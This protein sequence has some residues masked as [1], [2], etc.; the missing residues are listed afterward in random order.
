MS[1]THTLPAQPSLSIAP[2]SRPRPRPRYKNQEMPSA[3]PKIDV[4]LP[5]I[6]PLEDAE[7]SDL[8]PLSSPEEYEAHDIFHTQK[9][10][11]PVLPKS[12]SVTESPRKRQAQVDRDTWNVKALGPYVWV[13]IDRRARVF[14]PEDSDDMQLCS[15]RLWWPGKTSTVSSRKIPLKVRLFGTAAPGVKTVEI[16]RPCESNVVPWDSPQ[17]R[18]SVDEP[19]FVNLGSCDGNIFDSPTKKRKVD[20]DDRKKRWREALE[21]LARDKEEEGDSD[22][23]PEVGTLDFQLFVSASPKNSTKEAMRQTG[24]ETVKGKGKGKRKRRDSDS[25]SDADDFRMAEDER[26]AGRKAQQEEWSP[27]EP[28][29]LL[30]IPGEGVLAA[31]SA[32]CT[33][34]WPAQ[35][36]KYIPPKNSRQQPKYKVEYVGDTTKEI[37]RNWFYTVGDSEFATCEL[38]EW[39][40]KCNEVQDDEDED[41]DIHPRSRSPSPI[42]T[43]PPPEAD[44][45]IHLSVREQFAY[46]KPVLTAILNENY[47]PARPRH[48]KFIAGG[49]KRQST[50]QEAG[51]RGRMDPRDID[52]LEGCLI[53]WCLRD[54]RKAKA[55]IDEEGREGEASLARA[56]GGDTYGVN[57][58]SAD[59][60]SSSRLSPTGS[61]ATLPLS[62]GEVPPESSFP[63]EDSELPPSSAL[64]TSASLAMSSRSDEAPRTQPR[65]Y[66]CDAYEALSNVEKLDYCHN[67]LLPEAVLQILL[68]R[69]DFRRSVKLL[70]DAEE[71]ELHRKG[72]ELVSERDWVNDV[73]RLRQ[74][75]AKGKVGKGK[76]GKGEE[77]ETLYSVTGRPRR[78]VGA[79]KSYQE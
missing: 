13:L 34:Y 29:I 53:E 78:S 35:I 39:E 58:T 27:P 48:D 62:Q 19:M 9:P 2:P 73:M 76:A 7:E 52:H 37:P 47:P 45:F 56:D 79:P 6:L 10:T 66:G 75:L 36:L 41:D 28:D 44:E 63:T 74:Q 4:A 50:V 67:V 26:A 71:A 22:A 30:Q 33:K 61:D 55:I 49:S 51:L 38:G 43:E 54:E 20:K 25:E 12:M 11:S 24:V 46:V 59:D 8:S 68:W 15:E 14:D 77:G 69:G 42:P 21:E 40:D 64:G 18:I 3:P 57:A 1:S 72:R 60:V 31:W 17:H 70:S 32:A 23:M 16:H 5:P 65:Q